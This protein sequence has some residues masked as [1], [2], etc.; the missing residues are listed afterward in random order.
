MD[1][2]RYEQ[3]LDAILARD[4]RYARDAYLFVADAVTYTSRNMRQQAED[5]RETHHITGRQLLDG[6]REYA[7][8]QFGPLALD[9]LADW[10][11]AATEDIGNIVFAMVGEGLLGASEEDSP[12]DFADV[13]DLRETL[14][15]PFAAPAEPDPA[16]R[17]K[18][19]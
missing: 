17:P 10:G 3:K 16:E 19:A 11:I 13:Y 2:E 5:G 4:D 7:L 9:V 1:N 14:L 18:I 6:I 8:E 12:R 15:R